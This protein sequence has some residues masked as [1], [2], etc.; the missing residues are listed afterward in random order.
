MLRGVGIG[1][2]RELAPAL[3]ARPD[4]VA[5]VEVVAEACRDP[6]QRNEARALASIWPVVPHG[7]KLSLGSAEGIDDDRARA[8]GRLARETRAPCVSEHVAFVRAGG[9]EIGHL[10]DLPRTREAVAT[11]A[12]NVARLRA[13][14]PDV[15]LLLEN[16]A[17]TFAWTDHEMS[18]PDFYAE[19]VEASGC[20]L[21]LDVGNLYANALNSCVDAR[22]VLARFPLERIAMVHVAGGVLEDGFY[23]DTHAH[24]VPDPVYALVGCVRAV[25]PDVPVLLERDA[26]FEQEDVIFDEI[27]R[28]DREPVGGIVRWEGERE[29]VP[30]SGSL[31]DDQVALARALTGASDD[32]R[33]P[34]DAIARARHVLERKRADD[35]LPLLGRL[36]SCIAP[37]D[38]MSVGRITESPRLGAMTAVRDAWNIA[39]GASERPEFHAAAVEDTLVLRARFRRAASSPAPRFMPF[40]GRKRLP[41]GEVLWAW[42]SMGTDAPVR[43]VH[44]RGNGA[45]G[46]Q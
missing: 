35:A 26:H 19:I 1:W 27:E 10:T 33:F 23:F 41:S 3:L 25:R 12:R 38:A 36:R 2:R 30:S 11:V 21:L 39:S 44:R 5:F 18:E 46:V 29:R 37:E 31:A 17:S 22:D 43:V 8:L 15:P 20:E 4:R 32:E 16:V 9:R 7:V 40:V 34:I 24:P 45:K 42:K 13:R 28:L 14:L 6:A